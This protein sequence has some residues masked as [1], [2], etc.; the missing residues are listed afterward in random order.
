MTIR[1]ILADDHPIFRDG[2]VQSI[3]ETG[4]F[5]VV[6]VGESADDAIFLAKKHTPDVALLD[7]S[8]PGNG[9]TAAKRIS[10]AGT[11]KYIAM[12]TVSEDD[13]D[14]TAALEAGAIGY[15]LKGV[16]AAELRRILAGIAKGEAH[17]SPELAARV[18]KI[19]QTPKR[20]EKTPIDDLTKRE[21][22]ILRHVAT[23]KSN[24]EV[25]DQLGLQEK[26]VKHYMTT[27]LGKLH[28]R[29]RVEAALIAH[30][31]WRQEE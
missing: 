15:V 9:I 20:T 16:S 25:A 2:L 14:V 23:G 22:D 4:E 28:A 6:G 12:L 21:E 1:L 10:G 7:L 26:T 8:M 13:G 29:N 19:M 11:A 17:V 24:R 3:E 30:E 27:I 18:L 5:E 31:A